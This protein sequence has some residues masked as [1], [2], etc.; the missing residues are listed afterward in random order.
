[1]TRELQVGDRIKD[2]D[3]RM[4]GRAPLIVRKVDG[5]YAYAESWR[6]REFRLLL[7]RIY[8]DD[9]ARRTGFSLVKEAAMTADTLRADLS[10]ARDIWRNQ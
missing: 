4:A 1:M 2:N 6:G 3:P 7:N 5:Q 8:T 9:K 10:A